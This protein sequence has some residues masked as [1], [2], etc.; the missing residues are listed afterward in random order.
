VDGKGLDNP[1]PTR[2]FVLFQGSPHP[3][4]PPRPTC[5]QTVTRPGKPDTRPHK[6]ENFRAVA[7]RGNVTYLRV[8]FFGTRGFPYYG[9]SMRTRLPA[10]RAEAQQMARHA[11]F[12][13]VG[14]ATQGLANKLIASV[15]ATIPPQ[16]FNVPG[17]N[18][19]GT[20]VNIGGTIV[21]FPPTVKFQQRT[22][23]LV[24]TTI[25]IGGLFTISTSSTSARG[26]DVVLSAE[27]DVPI[28]TNV[29]NNNIITSID[30]SQV[31]ISGL[32]IQYLSTVPT[33]TFQTAIASPAMV[34]AIN[35]V[36][37]ALP[38]LPVSAPLMSA[39]ISES[40]S[41]GVPPGMNPPYSNRSIFPPYPN[42]CTIS[43]RIDRLVTQQFDNAITI[44]ADLAGITNGNASQLV[45]LTGAYSPLQCYIRT[46][47]T[48][49]SS[50]SYTTISGAPNTDAVVLVNPAVL[51]SVLA[52]TVSPA[53]DDGP[54]IDDHVI[55][56][57]ISVNLGM[58]QRGSA[59]RSWQ[60]PYGYR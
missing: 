55:I 44:A 60:W 15:V 25:T 4:T 21:I 41:R 22:D 18:V 11:G 33:A 10:D 5:S 42:R 16:S 58:V 34:S 46:Y 9:R 29:Q 56:H 26:I 3:V 40:I 8:T 17:I 38:A 59:V 12:A 27:L 19:G 13:I 30:F 57:N 47:N 32:G 49:L 31:V 50:T 23:D 2:S 24:A 35:A 39:S 36:I 20:A 51:N 1:V 7:T 45:D 48:D 14:S 6:P 28:S 53:F 37:R 54:M 52:N 43:L